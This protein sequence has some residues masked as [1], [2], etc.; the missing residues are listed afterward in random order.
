M[1]LL[2]LT[3]ALGLA[4]CNPGQDDEENTTPPDDKFPTAEFSVVFDSNGGTSVSKYNYDGMEGRRP[5]VKYDSKISAPPVTPVK[6]GYTFKFWSADGKKEF[7]F[8]IATI[9]QNTT[10]TAVYSAQI[11]THTVHLFENSELEPYVQLP[12]DAALKSTYAAAVESFVSPK[13]TKEG[14]YFCYWYYYK[15]TAAGSFELDEFG[16]KIQVRFSTWATKPVDGE[17]PETVTALS[18]YNFTQ[19]LDLYAMW[20]SQ[21]PE[22][23]VTYNADGGKL[24]GD[25]GG[26][27]P[28]KNADFKFNDKISTPSQP[29]R[30][31]YDFKGWYYHLTDKDGNVTQHD[32]VFDNSEDATVLDSDILS[33]DKENNVYSI[34][35][36]AKWVKNITMSSANDFDTYYNALKSS[37]TSESELKELVNANITLTA[38]ITLNK[39]YEPLFSAETPFKGVFDGNSKTVTGGKFAGSGIVSMLGYSNGT[40]KNLILKNTGFELSQHNGQFAGPS[41]IAAFASENGGLISGCTLENPSFN[42]NGASAVIIGGIAAKN[43]RGEISECKVM[44]TTLNISAESVTFGGIAGQNYYGTISKADVSLGTVSVTSKD[45]GNDANG[46]TFA[47]IGALVGENNSGVVLSSSFSASL[48]LNADKKA[49]AGGAIGKNTDGGSLAKTQGVV[50]LNLTSEADGNAGGLIGENLGSVTNCTVNVTLSLTAATRANAGGIAGICRN[51]GTTATNYNEKLGGVFYSYATGNVSATIT[52]SDGILNLGG[53]AGDN[54]NNRT[55]NSFSLCNLS[56]KAAESAKAQIGYIAGALTKISDYPGT[57]F[58]NGTSISLNGTS[59]AE[60]QDFKLTEAG[61]VTSS[62]DFKSSAFIIS[63]LQ[64]DAEVWEIYPDAEDKLPTL[65]NS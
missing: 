23:T 8:S 19:G 26:W 14:D 10:L 2:V 16:K 47:N 58:S 25:G 33:H 7:D 62:S 37:Q 9:R 31:G 3:L 38:D 21:L 11:Y 53:I 52:A 56:A 32:F 55:K 35:L 64:F 34:T 65:K 42:V 22:V 61:T 50:T 51:N 1:L 6:S 40:V 49:N 18:R 41:L 20:H 59:I 17:Y 57:Y 39:T 44:I 13:T 12:Q 45:D 60:L 43:I 15:K 63:N 28:T 29:I 4:A 46:I 5:K 27:F 24:E 30:A 36:Y 48:T 54:Y